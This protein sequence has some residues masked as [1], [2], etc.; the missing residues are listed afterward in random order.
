MLPDSDSDIWS[1]TFVEKHP[2]YNDMNIVYGVFRLFFIH[3]KSTES[4]Y[5]E[6]YVIPVLRKSGC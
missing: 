3:A 6:I 1:G 5:L 4:T 2:H